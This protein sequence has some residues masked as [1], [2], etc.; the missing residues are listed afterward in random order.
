MTPFFSFS[1]FFLTTGRLAGIVQYQS[2]TDPC[3]R[4]DQQPDATLAVRLSF[5]LMTF[6]TVIVI[7]AYSLIKPNTHQ[8]KIFV[9][10]VLS[11]IRPILTKDCKKAIM[12][13]G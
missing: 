5:P 9:L 8:V 4:T 6:P 12:M 2:M 10:F 11:H 3:F 1:F 7:A 13:G